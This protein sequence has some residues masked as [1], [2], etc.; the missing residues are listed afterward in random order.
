MANL[1]ISLEEAVVKQA[2]IRAIN[3]GTSVSAKVR[4]FLAEYA[5]GIGQQ[6]AAGLAFA[7]S[8]RASK[9]NKDGV[10]WTRQDA[11]ERPYP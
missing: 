7:K 1:T 9:A 6:R 11:Y 4:E 8:A 2:R 3:E 5:T 10:R